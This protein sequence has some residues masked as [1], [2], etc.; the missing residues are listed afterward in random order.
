MDIYVGNLPWSM[1]DDGLKQLFEEHGEVSSAK[2]IKDRETNRSRGFGFVSMDDDAA[3]TAISSL[4]GSEVDGRNL[5]V[6][7]SKGKS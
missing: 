4:D 6:N 7:K 2:I 3:E 1:D 5:K